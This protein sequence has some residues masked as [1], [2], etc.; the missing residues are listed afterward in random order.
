M[1]EARQFLAQV[2]AGS[3][4]RAEILAA[5]GDDDAAFTSLFR[6]LDQRDSWL[7]FIKS[8]PVF[9]ALR[10]DPRWGI[11]LQRMNLDD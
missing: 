11:V 4:Q 10:G 3:P 8:D 2:P 6:A 9:D 1:K 5:L 7:L